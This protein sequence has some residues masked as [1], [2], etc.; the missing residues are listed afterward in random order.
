MKLTPKQVQELIRCHTGVG[1]L[2]IKSD[3]NEIYQVE[4]FVSKNKKI[5]ALNDKIPSEELDL[6][7]VVLERYNENANW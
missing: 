6:N 2:I 7:K 3:D 4:F 1:A 5:C